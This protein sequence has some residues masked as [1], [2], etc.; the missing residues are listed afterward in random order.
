MQIM[1]YFSARLGVSHTCDEAAIYCERD[2]TVFLVHAFS[3]D[4]F[5]IE[6][7]LPK[8]EKYWPQPRTPL[9]PKLIAVTE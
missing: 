1:T 8:L 4:Y 5:H 9:L 3:A 6:E 2:R 7:S